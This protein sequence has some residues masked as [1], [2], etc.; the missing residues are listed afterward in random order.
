MTFKQFCLESKLILDLTE[1]SGNMEN[2]LR[3]LYPVILIDFTQV[4]FILISAV[5][6]SWKWATVQSSSLQFIRKKPISGALFNVESFGQEHR[7]FNIRSAN[8]NIKIAS[9]SFSDVLPPP[10]S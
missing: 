5:L 10:Q 6:S 7:E 1:L 8:R 9:I 2:M 4:I 3:V